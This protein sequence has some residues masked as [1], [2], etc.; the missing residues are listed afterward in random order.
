MAEDD[1]LLLSRAMETMRIVRGWTKK[2][3]SA[4]SGVRSKLISEYA[5]GKPVPPREVVLQLAAAMG[6]PEPYLD[7]TIAYMEGMQPVAPG[8]RGPFEAEFAALL[9]QMPGGLQMRA[10]IAAFGRQ[11]LALLEREIASDLWLFLRDPPIEA[12]R[13]AVETDERYHRWGLAER[14]AHESATAAADQEIRAVELAELAVGVAALVKGEEGWKNR[15]QGYA[16]A[17]LSN[18]QR[19]A[20]RSLPEAELTF[21]R[22][23]VLWL[24]GA[25]SDPG[26]FDESRF[27]ELEASLHRDQRR[28]H[29]SLACLEQAMR[30]AGPLRLPRLLVKKAK[31]LEEQGEHDEAIRLLEGVLPQ[32]DPAADRR[33]AWSARFNLVVNLCAIDRAAEGEQW[34]SELGELALEMGNGLDRIR[35]RWLQGKVHAGCGRRSEAILAL[36]EVRDEFLARGIAYDAALVS[37]ELAVV[38]LEEGRTAEVNEVARRLAPVFDSQGVHREALAALLVFRSAAEAEAATVVET[39][40]ILYFLRRAQLD[41][42]L[43]WDH[44][45]RANEGEA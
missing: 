14:I 29:E 30:Q 11:V 36:S 1:P 3:L 4:K 31:T 34:L 2:E 28:L 8:R 42:G 25:G 17:F 45:T 32:I 39:R 12:S 27:L 15:V 7:F 26:I 5:Q 24:A 33:L 13:L 41:P 23:K 21:A 19:V 37:L 18:A 6:Y 40:R 44:G 10:S 16:L 20:G 38:L 22:A 9:N 43:H 35:F